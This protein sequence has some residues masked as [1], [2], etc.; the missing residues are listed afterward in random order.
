ME[1]REE[2]QTFTH[3][4]HI[5]LF[6]MSHLIT[7]SIQR[8]SFL[9]LLHLALVACKKEDPAP[10]PVI[11]VIPT[12][13]VTALSP[14]NGELGTTV[15]ITGTN[16]STTAT[17]NAVLFNG[18]SATVVSA[19]ASSIV[20]QVPEGAGT[21]PVTVTTNGKTGTSATPFTYKLTLFTSLLAGSETPAMFGLPFKAGQGTSAS[22]SYA[23]QMF[24]SPADD[25][26]YYWEE[27]ITEGGVLP[28]IK[29]VYK[30]TDGTTYTISTLG[31]SSTGKAYCALT[32][33]S[34]DKQTG[35]GR[36]G[37]FSADGTLSLLNNTATGFQSPFTDITG[38]LVRS[39]TEFYVI[40]P[41]SLAGKN[42]KL[43]K[44]TGT[45]YTLLAGDAN[46]NDAGQD[47][48]GTGATFSN[49]GSSNSIVADAAGN[50]LVFDW[51]SIRKI[52]ADGTITTMVG[53]MGNYTVNSSTRQTNITDGTGTQVVLGDASYMT[54][55]NDG[56][57][58]LTDAW[59]KFCRIVS[60][61]GVVTTPHSS[62]NGQ[63]S[64]LKKGDFSSANSIYGAVPDKQGN[65]YVPGFGTGNS[66][67]Q[68]IWKFTFR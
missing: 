4:L 55:G 3:L 41:T 63:Q 61:A 16:F 42:R 65:L 8:C 22:T 9:L 20:A 40:G 25:N 53:K 68:G 48:K 10:T 58:Y 33:V 62:I 60:P 23:R 38:F 54:I 47:G 27:P 5:T 11:P 46:P 67:V 24:N 28:R 44:L 7:T 18:K 35:T 21:G 17:Q 12:P 50:L 51:G 39:D 13:T 64:Y 36:I 57:I 37:F 45:G 19:N 49:Y 66:G 14:D 6:A 31:F 26:L 52:T 2:N 1:G 30:T 56:T 32:G 29:S 59:S 43:Y 15:T 34:A